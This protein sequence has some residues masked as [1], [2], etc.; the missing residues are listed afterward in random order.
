MSYVTKKRAIYQLKATYNSF[1]SSLVSKS[2]IGLIKA[3]HTTTIRALKYRKSQE[4]FKNLRKQ[5]IGAL[6]T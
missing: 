2:G 4:F 3:S 5:F 1:N 6:K